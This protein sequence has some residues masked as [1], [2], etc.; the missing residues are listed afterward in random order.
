MS[1][2]EA[3]LRRLWALPNL[4]WLAI[5][6]FLTQMTFYST[7][8]VAFQSERGLNLTEMF[9]LESLLSLT[10]FLFEVPTG[11]LADRPALRHR[12]GGA[13]GLRQRPA[14]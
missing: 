5:T 8:I 2:G 14:L 12:A 4:R 9:L 3:G 10:I 7:V 13:V 6:Q 11:I 1:F